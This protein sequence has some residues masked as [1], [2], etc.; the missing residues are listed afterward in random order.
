MHGQYPPQWYPGGQEFAPPMG[1]PWTNYAPYPPGPMNVAPSGPPGAPGAPGAHGAPG[2]AGRQPLAQ[3]QNN[4][5]QPQKPAPIGPAAEKKPATPGKQV[6][7]ATDKPQ[8]QPPKQAAAPATAP[9]APTPPI[10]SKPT[11]EQVKA[12]TASLVN[13]SPAVASREPPKAAPTGPKNTRPTQILPAVPLPAALTAKVSQGQAASKSGADLNNPI[14]A[15]SLRD[16]TQAAR[17][18][19]AVA[20]A[21]IGKPAEIQ[22]VAAAPQPNG[23]TAMDNL[24]RKVNEMRVNATRPTPAAAPAVRGNR[25]GRGAARPA[26]VEV[27]DSDFDFASAN[28]KFNKHDLV[29]EAIAGTPLTEAPSDVLASEL[30]NE[31]VDSVP[32]AYNKSRS[33]F[34]NISSEAKDRLDNNGMKPGGR[35][36]R[37]EEQRKNMETFGQGSVDGGYRGYRGG[38]GRGRGGRGGRNYRGGRGGNIPRPHNPQPTI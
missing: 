15:A 7:A 1:P 20:M 19:V 14:T 13:N 18:A 30:A 36:W 37:G 5:P 29:K 9:S 27:P 32:P 2:Q 26:K 34:D 33:F 24:T 21:N 3:A 4:Q 6:E 16:A 38:R 25:G 28:A 23:G 10:E 11:V 8:V 35:E 12:T 31:S 22:P 17:E